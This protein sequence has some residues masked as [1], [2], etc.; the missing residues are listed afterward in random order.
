MKGHWLLVLLVI[1]ATSLSCSG[2]EQKNDDPRMVLIFKSDTFSPTKVYIPKDLSDCHVQLDGMLHKDINKF[3]AGERSH[4]AV[5]E[6]QIF[7]Y[8]FGPLFLGSILRDK[9][10][11]LSGSRLAIYFNE[12]GLKHPADML[13]VIFDSYKARLQHQD[14]DLVA[15]IEHYKEISSKQTQPPEFI[16][17]E[18]GGRVSVALTKQ[19]YILGTEDPILLGVNEKTGDTWYYQAEKG[20]YKPS[21]DDLKAHKNTS[22]MEVLPNRG[23][24]KR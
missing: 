23:D 15:T 22:W 17:P 13:A 2:N 21:P 4:L 18:S 20:W 7:D 16:D 5:E 9:W 6:A 1:A 24:T 11:L 8:Y 10:G 3:L 14:Y 19:E 12:L